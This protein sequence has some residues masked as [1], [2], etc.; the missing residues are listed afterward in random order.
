[1]G[2]CLVGCYNQ[3]CCYSCSQYYD[4]EL[5]NSSESADDYSF[6]GKQFLA[7]IMSVYDGDT[8][9]VKF[10]AHDSKRLVQY[11]ARLYDINAPEMKPKKSMLHREDEIKAATLARDALRKRILH[12]EVRI[13]CKDFDDF[14]RILLTVYLKDENINE[15][16]LLNGYAKRWK[17]KKEDKH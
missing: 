13:E 17:K 5:R 6:H 11:R 14:G 10:R 9:R 12:R 4:P 3:G 15:W 8:V 7:K 16:M 1:M 2:N